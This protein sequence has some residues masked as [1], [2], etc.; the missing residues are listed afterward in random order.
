MEVSHFVAVTYKTMD[1]APGAYMGMFHVQCMFQ[2]W[3]GKIHPRCSS[4]GSY[5][6]IIIRI[7]YTHVKIIFQIVFDHL[8]VIFIPDTPSLLLR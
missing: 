4:L 7:G 6:K 5:Q 3:S 2:R 8:R 1:I